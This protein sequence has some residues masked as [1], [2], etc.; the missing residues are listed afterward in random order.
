MVAA[1]ASSPD[2]ILAR[3]RIPTTSPGETIERLVA[4]FTEAS[5]DHAR[6]DALTVGTFGPADLDS[7]SPTYGFI[8]T[9]PKPGWQ[10]T[11]LLGP[12][13]KTLGVPAVFETDVDA[14]LFGEA[15]WGAARGL[16]HAAY[17]TIGTGIGGG[18]MID[19]RMVH[20]TGHPEMGH[21]RVKRHPEDSFQGICPYH[22]DC[23][24]GLASGSALGN[25]WHLPA[26]ELP[27]DHLAWDF[28]AWYLAQACLNILTIAPPQRLILG[29][30]VMH[31]EHL[32]PMIRQHLSDL[33]QDYLPCPDGFDQ[34]IVGPAL[35]DNAGLLGCV[36]LGQEL[37][38]ETP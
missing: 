27:A 4:F 35:G 13:Q 2:Q 32:F 20:G 28:Q 22:H 10:N 8:T 25:R 24:E 37:L 11:D 19:G 7:D 14:S 33:L 31:Q 12:L 9:T 17:L 23:L 16:R 38:R 34:L 6:P 29:G 1:L 18:L 26:E 36:A 15:T 21:M 5:R 30:G 3:K